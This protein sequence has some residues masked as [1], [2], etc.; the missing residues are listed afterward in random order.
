MSKSAARSSSYCNWQRQEVNLSSRNQGLIIVPGRKNKGIIRTRSFGANCYAQFRKNFSDNM[1][2]S[3]EDLVAVVEQL[4]LN[5]E[6]D[7]LYWCYEKSGVYSSQL[8]YAVIYFRG[9]TPVH[10]RVV[11]NIV[12]PPKRHL[13]MWI[14][15]HN[16]LATVDNLNKKRYE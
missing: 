4:N 5:E 1:M 10:V 8:F 16:K 15:S 12:V 6:S 9:L 11:W 2:Q 14:L 7:A 13:S 3:W